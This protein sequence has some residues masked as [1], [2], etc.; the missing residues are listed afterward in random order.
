MA[1]SH[2]VK[3]E[4]MPL[5][6]YLVTCKQKALSMGT[7]YQAQCCFWNG[8]QSIEI[9]K[10][11]NQRRQSPWAPWQHKV[12]YRLGV[13]CSRDNE[14]LPNK[15]QQHWNHRSN[16]LVNDR[17]QKCSILWKAFGTPRNGQHFKDEAN[18]LELIW[19]GRCPVDQSLFFSTRIFQCLPRPQRGYWAN[20]SKWGSYCIKTIM[21]LQEHEKVQPCVFVII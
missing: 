14:Q 20:E 8:V 18:T 1:T 13:F 21:M 12:H 16:Y 10:L 4:V 9:R 19:Q 15:K 2:K 3:V 17:P 5:S 6:W 11:Y 7:L